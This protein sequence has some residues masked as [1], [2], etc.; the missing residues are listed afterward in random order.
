M[1]VI[2]LTLGYVI[3]A[4]IHVQFVAVDHVRG[5]FHDYGHM[6]DQIGR[7][8][9]PGDGPRF[10]GWTRNPRVLLNAGGLIGTGVAMVVW[11]TLAGVAFFGGDRAILWAAGGHE[12]SREAAPRVWNVVEEMTIAAGLPKPPRVF[13]ID[14]DGMNA[15]AVGLSP[16]HAAVAVTAGLVKRMNRDEL[17]GVVAHEIAHIHNYDI[18]FMTLASIMVGS[19]VI[20]SETFLRS[21]WYST[22][23]RSSSSGKNSGGQALLLIVAVIFAVLA[24]VAAHILYFA[25]SRK[26]EYLADACAA[27]FT[28]YPPGLASALEKIGRA[29]PTAVD[30]SKS[31]V[32]LYIANPKQPMSASSVFA[33]HPPLKKRIAIL[34]SMSGAGYVDYENAFRNAMASS[35][36]L[37]NEEFLRNEASVPVRSASVE[38]SQQDEAMERSREAHDALD[39]AADYAII[40]CAC[41]VRLRLPPGMHRDAVSCP[42]C[43]RENAVPRARSASAGET[44]TKMTE[45]TY[46]RTTTGWESFRCVCGKTIQLS[47]SFSAARASCRS[48]GRHVKI[49]SLENG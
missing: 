7:A 37:L 27:R 49:S 14:D 30:V 39:R 4:A 8:E 21:V 36:A 16:D 44:A 38:T 2:L 42:R 18:R 28:R 19:I 20:V 46:Q 15:F 45:S 48:C 33:T 24:P 34:R 29:G 32:P 22:P 10:F 26:R 25:C 23:R 13:L 11:I 1:G 35:K 9:D 17:Q 40:P 41:G 3:G 43:G 5:G 12:I 47:P 6:L 31:L